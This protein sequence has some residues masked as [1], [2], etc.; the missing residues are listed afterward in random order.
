MCLDPCLLP[1]VGVTAPDGVLDE[2]LGNRRV[3]NASYHHVKTE[4]ETVSLVQHVALEY[5]QR[6]RSILLD[7]GGAHAR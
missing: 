3:S 1:T 4:R 2:Q 5:S 7:R 6:I